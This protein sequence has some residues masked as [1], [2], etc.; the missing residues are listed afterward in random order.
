M[1]K[2]AKPSFPTPSYADFCQFL[3]DNRAYTN[4]RKSYKEYAGKTFS[5]AIFRQDFNQEFPINTFDWKKSEQGQKY[6][7]DLDRKW[8][9]KWFKPYYDI[10]EGRKT[11]TVNSTPETVTL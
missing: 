3:K 4:F 8:F 6:W 9:E 2:A 5:E 11:K 1:A 7:H 10:V